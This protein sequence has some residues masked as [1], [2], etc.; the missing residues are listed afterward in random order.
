MDPSPLTLGVLTQMLTPAVL[1]S[2]CGALILSTSLRLGR[3]VDRVRTLSDNFEELAHTDDHV[4]LREERQA[5]L[6]DLLDKLTSRARLLGRSITTFYVTLGV[7][8]ATSVTLGVVSVT[9]G[10]RWLPVV[11]T[12]TGL[13]SLL[14]GC[15][16]LILEARLALRGLHA[17]MDFLWKLGQ[18]H[19]PAESA[20]PRRR[21]SLTRR[22]KRPKT[23]LGD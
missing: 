18:R 11:L 14:Y 1:I 19:A 15:V 4:E 3:V 6:F 21:L 16:L 5:L 10:Y 23:G 9:S 12:W 20:R 13:A 8:V 22:Y 2:A 7:F 17:E